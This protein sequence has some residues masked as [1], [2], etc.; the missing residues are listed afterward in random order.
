VFC[1]FLLHIPNFIATTTVVFNPPIDF[2]SFLFSVS[3]CC[4]AWQSVPPAQCFS[5]TNMSFCFV[6]VSLL[7]LVTLEVNGHTLL[8]AGWRL[9]ISDLLVRPGLDKAFRLRTVLDGITVF[10]S[11]GRGSVSIEHSKRM[12]SIAVTPPSVY[13]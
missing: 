11:H 9:D 4:T 8:R 5:C 7:G 12:A 6:L 2:P 10:L 13:K 3:L 1:L